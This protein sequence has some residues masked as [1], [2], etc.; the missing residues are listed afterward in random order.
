MHNMVRK[1]IVAEHTA[2]EYRYIAVVCR[3]KAIEAMGDD[4]RLLLSAA[5]TDEAVAK[6][7]LDAA[8]NACEDAGIP[9]NSSPILP[10]L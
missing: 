1:Q 6:A 5:R 7:D 3:R 9:V 2:A 4:Y 10:L 8:H